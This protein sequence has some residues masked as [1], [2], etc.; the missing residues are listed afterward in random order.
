MDQPPGTRIHASGFSF[1]MISA[2][3]ADLWLDERG[4]AGRRSLS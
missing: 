3:V 2:R 1:L 4:Q